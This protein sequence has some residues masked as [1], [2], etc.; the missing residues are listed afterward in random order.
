MGEKQIIAMP[1]E[2]VVFNFPGANP[3]AMEKLTAAYGDIKDQILPE[4]TRAN[5]SDLH[6]PFFQEMAVPADQ[7]AGV[8]DCLLKCV[9]DQLGIT[10]IIELA[11]IGSGA[12]L[13]KKRFVTPGSSP[14]SSIASKYIPKAIPSRFKFLPKRV[15]APTVVRP[16]AMSKLTGRVL[17]RWIPF[18][19][20]G[21]LAYD[22]VQITRCAI[23][24]N[25]E[26]AK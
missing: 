13:V 20:W 17:A 23:R 15:W 26:A 10:T 7:D 2:L 6:P 8:T 9:A 12:P 19:G 16:L 18:V 1:S 11:A 21:L 24:C 4:N 3:P 14:R 5:A 25:S 22:A